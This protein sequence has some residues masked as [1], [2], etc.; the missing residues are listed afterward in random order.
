MSDPLDVTGAWEGIFNYPRAMP[1]GGF[2]ADLREA[3]GAIAG[4]TEER[5]DGDEAGLTLHALVTGAR[6]GTAVSFTKS[7]DDPAR[8]RHPVRYAGTIAP[9][10]DEIT[11]RW[12][13][14]GHWSG[15][16]IMVRAARRAEPAAIE[17]AETVR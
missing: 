3:A 12:D 4:E 5:G 6:S 13:I 2:R 14:A 7:Y 17:V 9:D 1:P 15:S 11:G 16:F 8:A 10:G